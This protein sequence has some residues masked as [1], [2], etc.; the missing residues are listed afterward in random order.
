MKSKNLIWIIAVIACLIFFIYTVFSLSTGS[1]HLLT[2]LSGSMSPAVNPGDVVV[3]SNV[4]PDEIKVN[5]IITFKKDDKFIFTHR[6]VEVKKENPVQFRTKGD[7]NEEA[8]AGFVTSEEVLGKVILTIPKLGYLRNFV[9]SFLGFMLLIVIPGV[10]IIYS[11]TKKILKNKK[12]KN[13]PKA[14]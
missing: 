2:V 8:D 10:L 11:E 6:I 13:K 4:N 1:A 3:I 14:K 7:A 12:G 5:D 9:R